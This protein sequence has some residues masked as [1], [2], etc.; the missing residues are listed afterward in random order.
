M[1][2]KKAKADAPSGDEPPAKMNRTHSDYDELDFSNE[3]K[4]KDGNKWNF[5]ISTW[6]VDGLRAWLKKDGLSFIK[7]EKP[8]VICFQVGDRFGWSSITIPG[9]F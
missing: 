7:H 4:T 1:G 8:D 2:P 5:K 9:R 3:S 6:N